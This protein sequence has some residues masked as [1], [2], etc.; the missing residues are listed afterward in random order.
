MAIPPSM[1]PDVAQR[2][3]LGRAQPARPDRRREAVRPRSQ[4]GAA[5]STPRCTRCSPRSASSASTTTSARRA[6][7]TCSSSA[8]R[9]PARA[10]LEPQLRAQRAG[11]DVR[12]D[13]RRG[14]RLVL[15]RGRRDPRRAPEPP[16]AGR[17]AAGDGAARRARSQV[18]AGR[19]GQGAAA[20]EPIDPTDVVRGQYVGYRDEPGSPPIRR[21]RRS[22]PPLGDRL[23]ALG[24]GAVVRARRQGARRRRDRGGRRVPAPPRLLFDEAGGPTP[25]AT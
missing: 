21:P 15:R 16:A 23:V 19:E 14:P 25:G 24:R 17:R 8:S 7:R 3:G 18:P 2:L 1:F 10:D 5:S 6:S 9:T 13:R 11:H 22:S 20:M 4:V 12:D